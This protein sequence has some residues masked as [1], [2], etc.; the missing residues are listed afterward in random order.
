MVVSL[1]IS[2]MAVL[3]CSLFILREQYIGVSMELKPQDIVVGLLI[4]S[5]VEYYTSLSRRKMAELA[6]LS[7][8]EIANCYKRL[9]NLQLI[10]AN[11][12]HYLASTTGDNRFSPHSELA[13]NHYAVDILRR[14][15]THR[16]NT[17]AMTE[18]LCYGVR[19]YSKPNAAG[20]GRGMLTGWNCP[21]LDQAGGGM[22]PRDIPLA[23]PDAGGQSNGELITPIHPCAVSASSRVPLVYAMCAIIDVMRTGK[24]RE[25]AIARDLINNYMDRVNEQQLSW[26]KKY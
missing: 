25:V 14:L 4:G 5:E 6:H 20:Y 19:Y 23:W 24:P 9:A 1:A 15:P 17:V 22:I 18:F 16:L 12:G 7:V 2:W 21:A 3:V 26:I 11:D 13:L 10:I 8:G